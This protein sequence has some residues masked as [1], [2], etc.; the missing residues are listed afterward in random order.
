MVI[1]PDVPVAATAGTARS[2]RSL[3]RWSL[4][5]LALLLVVALF[6][7]VLPRLASYKSIGA[8]LGELSGV[9]IAGRMNRS[10]RMTPAERAV[11]R[12]APAVRA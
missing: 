4:D 10:W 1:V 9:A 11:L 2:R 12:G 3:R 5:L 6:G 8:V 7:L